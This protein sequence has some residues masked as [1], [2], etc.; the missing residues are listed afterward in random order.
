MDRETYIWNLG[1]MFGVSMV[2]IIYSIAR[3]I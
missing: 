3:I 2:V 1:V